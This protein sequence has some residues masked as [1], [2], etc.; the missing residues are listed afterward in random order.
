MLHRAPF[1]MSGFENM[2]K[3]NSISFNLNKTH[4]PTTDN[5]G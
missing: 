2:L 3:N 5:Y 1:G 4:H